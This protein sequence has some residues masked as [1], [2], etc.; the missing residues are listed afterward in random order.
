MWEALEFAKPLRI[1]HG[2][3]AVHDKKLMQE[4]VKRDVVLEV[5]PLSNLATR[6]VEDMDEM[7]EIFRTLVENKVKFTINTDWP[8]VIE[9]AHL[10]EQFVLL[11]EKGVLTEDQLK[12]CNQIAFDS[13]FVPPGGLNA[14][15]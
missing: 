4:L 3:R 15:L 7:E 13:T 1:G 12:Q 11:K 6:A 5:C 2:I 14:Y 10:R 8:E 9:N